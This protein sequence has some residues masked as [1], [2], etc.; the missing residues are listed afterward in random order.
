MGHIFI[1]SPNKKATEVTTCTRCEKLKCKKDCEQV[2]DDHI[3]CDACIDVTCQQCWESVSEIECS[4]SGD[5][6]CQ[7][8]NV[9]NAAGRMGCD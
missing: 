2:D 3:I 5:W 9:G 1:L 7:D 8:C 6:I 4:L